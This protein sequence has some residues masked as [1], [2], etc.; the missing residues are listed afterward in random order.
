MKSKIAKIIPFFCCFTLGLTPMVAYG[1]L[2]VSPLTI[3]RKA[4]SGQARGVIEIYNASN[5]PYRARVSLS[6]EPSC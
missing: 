2:S 6:Q 5:K 4:E 1:Q 3:Q